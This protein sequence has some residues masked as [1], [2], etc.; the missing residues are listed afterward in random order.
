M[1]TKGPAVD[2][3]GLQAGASLNSVLDA[4]GGRSGAGS[5]HLRETRWQRGVGW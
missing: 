4:V 3:Q 2:A 1:G 5:W